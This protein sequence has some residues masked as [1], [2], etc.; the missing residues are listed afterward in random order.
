GVV[1]RGQAAGARGVRPGRRA[2]FATRGSRPSS[3]GRR[4][5]TPRAGGSAAP[6]SQGPRGLVDPGRVAP[7]ALAAL[8]EP[9][10][11]QPCGHCREV[12]GL[13]EPA[14]EAPHPAPPLAGGARPSVVVAAV[15][16]V[17]PGADPAAV[18][19]AAILAVYVGA[20]AGTHE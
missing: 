14:G 9:P 10:H 11:D 13:V 3:G 4:S 8:A 12:D 17:V 18:G 5:A 1:G 20:A 2:R 19:A 15:G 7:G 16:A 6:A